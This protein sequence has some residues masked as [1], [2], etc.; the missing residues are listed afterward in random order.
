MT[1]RTPAPKVQVTKWLRPKQTDVGRGQEPYR[2]P[3]RRAT[4]VFV[5]PPE[6]AKVPFDATPEGHFWKRRL[7]AGE[8]EEFEPQP[9]PARAK[10]A[11]PTARPEVNNG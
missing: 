7:A 4:G 3:F 2:L 5:L 8:V 10:S 6:G 11:K 9:K 1:R